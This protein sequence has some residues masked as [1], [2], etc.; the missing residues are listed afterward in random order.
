MNYINV[1]HLLCMCEERS[2]MVLGVPSNKLSSEQHVQML[3]EL[4]F[5]IGKMYKK[6]LEPC[7]D[8]FS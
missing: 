8:T 1:I 5:A 6:R 4:S 7:K 2:R 3:F